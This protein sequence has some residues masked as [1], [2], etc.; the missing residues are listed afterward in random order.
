MSIFR[1]KTTTTTTPEDEQPRLDGGDYGIHFPWVS[2]IFLLVGIASEITDALLL[3]NSL[4][5]VMSVDKNDPRALVIS[6]ITGMVCFFSMAAIGYQSANTKV[7]YKTKTIEI[8]IWLVVGIYLAWL[9]IGLDLKNIETM[10]GNFLLQQNVVMGGL[11]ILLY[12]GTGFM[13]YAATKQ[14]TNAKLYEYMMAKYEYNKLLDEIAD[15]RAYIINGVSKLA[16]Y[17]GYAERLK[18]S[19]NSVLSNVAHYN[20]SVK[21]LCEAKMAVTT[22]PDHMDDM[23]NRALAREK[24]EKESK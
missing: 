11:Q 1:K 15:R 13:T 23:Y 7:K 22:E 17:P 12:I 18:Q 14:L 4:A 3:N 24:S 8:A 2:V 20:Q 9:R 10:E 5:Q 16:L 19:K 6:I 21:S